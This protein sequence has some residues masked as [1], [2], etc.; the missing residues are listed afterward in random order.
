MRRL[1]GIG[2]NRSRAESMERYVQARIGGNAPAETTTK[3]A[4]AKFEHDRAR[5]V[6]GYAGPQLHTHAVFFNVTETE[7]GKAHS[8]QPQAGHR[9]RG[10]VI[11][12]A[13]A[14]VHMSEAEVARD[15]HAA[16]ARVQQG[17]EI[18][19]EQDHRPV[20]VLKPSASTRPGRKLSECIELAKA[21]EAKLGYAPIPDENFARDVQAG[22][23][24]RRDS[25][26][27]PAW[28]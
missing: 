26:E 20:A 23:D 7:S 12:E 10:R 8:V 19:I 17:V 4:V 16:L 5:P 3:W 11:M 18:V 9:R 27:P 15:L 1:P 24:G 14:T 28:D 2:E 6:A 21:Y 13:M 22:I 25:F